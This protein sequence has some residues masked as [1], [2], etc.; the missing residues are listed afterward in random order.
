[1]KNP[2]KYFK[3][4]L[5]VCQTTLRRKYKN[6]LTLD[7][8]SWKVLFDENL[9]PLNAICEMEG[10]SK[11]DILLDESYASDRVFLFKKLL[12]KK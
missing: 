1:M 11:L 4:W 5:Y 2:Y 6:N 9:S 3:A 12:K 7:S 10:L 8:N